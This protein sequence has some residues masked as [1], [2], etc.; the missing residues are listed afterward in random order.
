MKKVTE[1]FHLMPDI[2][3]GATIVHVYGNELV[4]V[5]NYRSIIDYSDTCIKIQGKYVKIVICGTQL[6]IEYFTKDDCSVRG[7]VNKVEYIPM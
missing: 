5:E 4:R 3:D 6:W 1:V 7:C 2:L